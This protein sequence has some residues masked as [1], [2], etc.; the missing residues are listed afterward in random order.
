MQISPERAVATDGELAPR[1]R[2]RRLASGTGG[3]WVTRIAA[4]VLAVLRVVYAW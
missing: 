1:P 4:V 2:W 3:S